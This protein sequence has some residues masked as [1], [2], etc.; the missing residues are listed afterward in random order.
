MLVVGMV[1]TGHWMREWNCWRKKATGPAWFQISLDSSFDTNSS[2][3]CIHTHTHTKVCI[4][5]YIYKNMCIYICVYVLHIYVFTYSIL[6]KSHHGLHLLSM[7]LLF[8]NN[9]TPQMW[10]SYLHFMNNIIVLISVTH[11]GS[12]PTR[13]SCLSEFACIHS[14]TLL[15]KKVSFRFHFSTWDTQSL[16]NTTDCAEIAL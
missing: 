12:S 3:V 5:I 11:S 6:V 16:P 2:H 7:K 15:Q 14:V 13:F 8:G 1:Q 9:W 10:I 4:N